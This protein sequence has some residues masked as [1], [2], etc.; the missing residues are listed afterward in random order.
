VSS[1]GTGAAP[2][3]STDRIDPTGSVH[4]ADVLRLAPLVE[5]A[6]ALRDGAT[7]SVALVSA[8]QAAADRIDPLIGTYVVRFDR[9]ALEAAAAADEARARGDGSGLLH[10]VPFGV[11]DILATREG[12]TTAQSAALD[13]AWGD[14]PEGPVV[15]RL[16]AA[17]AIPLGKT[18]TMEFAVGYPDHEHHRW[19][20]GSDGDASHPFPLPRNPWNRE[21]W[22]GGSSSGTGNGVAAGLFPMGLGTDTGGSI[23]IP[24]AFCGVS[25]HKPTFGLVPK[26]GCVPLGFSYDHIGPLARSVADCAAVLDVIAGPDPSDPTSRARPG[27]PERYLDA[28]EQGIDGL[29]IGV[30]RS[31]TVDGPWC[32]AEVTACFD[33][34]LGALEEAGARLVE[35]DL[36]YWDE[37]HDATFLG[38]SA[39]A[40]AWHRS[41]LQQRWE[42]YGRPTRLSLALGALISGA[43]F[44]QAQRVRRTGRRLVGELFGSVDVIV[45]PTCGTVAPPFGGGGPDRTRQLRSIFT[46]VFN[47]LGFPALS[48][49]MGLDATL[50]LPTSLQIVAAPFEDGTALRVGHAFQ[51]VT[52]WHRRVP[53]L[54]GT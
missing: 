16:R 35:V 17:G 30:G 13:P 50:G 43:D 46:A 12:P 49:P 54:A 42:D 22:A 21:H 51:Q 53:A 32:D 14:Q 28:L 4:S 23:R 25:G 6:A 29:R 52:D 47:A 41:M 37:L 39:E 7:T 44:A 31:A 24:A 26:S 36:P 38:M 40:F 45:T 5:Q 27:G 19:D 11:K 1:A 18:T 20:D 8:T 10:G 48:V 34:A 2:A 15:S 9:E 3:A 33:E